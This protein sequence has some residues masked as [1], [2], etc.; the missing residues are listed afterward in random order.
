MISHLTSF[1]RIKRWRHNLVVHTKS[2]VLI[3]QKK[4]DNWSLP[5]QSIVQR[6]GPSLPRHAVAARQYVSSCCACACA[7]WSRAWGCG[8]VR[9]RRHVGAAAA[10][11]R[12]SSACSSA[13]EGRRSASRRQHA[14]MASCTSR[15]HAS[16]RSRHSN[17]PSSACRCDRF[18]NTYRMQKLIRIDLNTNITKHH[19]K[20]QHN[21][22]G[23]CSYV[24]DCYAHAPY[25]ILNK[26]AI[27]TRHILCVVL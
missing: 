12:R 14:R 16:G 26:T 3:G 18:S 24:T 20:I 27:G 22:N 15:G 13:K 1:Q 19:Y 11:A 4:Y 9:A 21:R 6:A 23:Q 10:A 17:M 5:L 2:I 8:A 7:W 25:H